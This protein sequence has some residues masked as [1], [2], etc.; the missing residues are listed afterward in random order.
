MPAKFGKTTRIKVVG[1]AVHFRYEQWEKTDLVRAV[2]HYGAAL[3]DWSPVFAKF[4]PYQKA[5]LRRNFEAQGRPN[6]WRRLARR[7]LADRRRKG[8]G[9]G[10]IL[11]RSG[12]LKRGFLGD[13]GKT[14]FRINNRARSRRGYPYFWPH[15]LGAP[16][17]NIPQRIMVVLLQQDQAQFT[18][19]ARQHIAYRGGV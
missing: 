12:T 9:P 18:R 5:S 16:K 13:W 4:W 11:V 7:T 17:A 6:R 1:G 2:E 8:Y 19:L 15:Q 14:Y 3:D 10:P